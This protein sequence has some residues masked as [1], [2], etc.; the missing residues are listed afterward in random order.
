LL[1]SL[2]EGTRASIA[3][4]RAAIETML[5]FPDM[6]NE[7]RQ[8]FA[9]II[10]DE[11]ESL[12]LRLTKTLSEHADT[13][14]GQWPMED[15]LGSDLLSAIQRRM[16]S[17]L[18]VTIWLEPMETP[19][20]LSVDSYS[21]VQAMTQVMERVQADFGVN[22]ALLTLKPEGR[23]AR[24]E[25][26]WEGAPSGGSIAD[27]ESLLLESPGSGLLLT[28]VLER[29]GGEAWC[30]AEKASGVV[31]FCMHLPT[32]TPAT[33][34]SAPGE[35]ESRPEYYDF[36]LFSQPGQ[37]PELDERKLTEL[38]YT[39]FDTE[40]TGLNPTGG[41]EIISLGAVRIV[42]GRLLKREV[43]DQ[44]IDPRRPVSRESLDIHGIVPDMLVGQ[45]VIDEVLPSFH[46]FA[47]DT[48]LVAH[49]AAFDMRFL[50][51]KEART[52]VRFIQPVL[53][54]LL[55]SAVAHPGFEDAEHSL[56]A[57]AARLGV[58][59]FGRHS[60]LGDAIVTGEIFLRLVPLL[61]DRGIHTLKEAREASRKTLYARLEY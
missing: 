17:K 33:T 51:L 58:N 26:R 12:S 36:D 6:T 8:R 24:L 14:R 31:R 43:F 4:I 42:N 18:G 49:N 38:A 5:G 40:T 45:P 59:V 47:E 60:A 20:W 22:G 9:Q 25:M 41:D 46:R 23:F 3:N 28:Q 2:T 19:I 39:V 61:A 50:Q 44:L 57:I 13:M 7:R 30:A 34:R 15:M 27:W 10:N 35:L 52:G 54:T 29:H 16:H 11:A 1:Q 55:L 53:D 37:N 32:T 21:V 48:V 56:E